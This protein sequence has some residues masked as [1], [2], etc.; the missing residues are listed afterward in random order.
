MYIYFIYMVFHGN[1][2]LIFKWSFGKRGWQ[3]Y[4]V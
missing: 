2:M 1:V 3:F 4:C